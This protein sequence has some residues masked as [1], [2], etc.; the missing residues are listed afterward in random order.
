MKKSKP[1]IRT[2]Y[3]SVNDSY[4]LYALDGNMDAWRILQTAECKA[5]DGSVYTEYI[6]ISF[7]NTVLECIEQGY[8]L[9]IE[10]NQEG[11]NDPL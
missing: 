11:A 10:N 5:V 7:L 2:I 3:N 8:E 4:E 6:S 9:Y 1:Q